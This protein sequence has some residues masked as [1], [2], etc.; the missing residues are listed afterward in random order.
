MSGISGEDADNRGR[1]PGCDESVGRIPVEDARAL[2]SAVCAA[3]VRGAYYLPKPKPPEQIEALVRRAGVAEAP[4]SAPGGL[5]TAAVI[6]FCGEVGFRIYDRDGSEIGAAM[7]FKDRY[8]KVGYSRHHELLDTQ[9][10]CVLRDRT[11]RRFG[12]EWGNYRFSVLGADEAE[13]GTITQS[14]SRDDYVI[15]SRGR[16]VA[17]IRRAPNLNGS[18]SAT[19]GRRPEAGCA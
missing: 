19:E 9:L 1:D 7:A 11:R 10:R 18:S 14:G 16:D 6:V 2:P 8:S 13:I 5:S 15:A 17:T 4:G 12:S 3:I